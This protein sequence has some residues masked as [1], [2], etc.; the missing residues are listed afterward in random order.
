MLINVDDG[1]AK[2]RVAAVDPNCCKPR[3][4]LNRIRPAC[5]RIWPKCPDRS[6]SE[7]SLRLWPSFAADGST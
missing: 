2:Q 4:R 6:K 3:Q 7:P 1:L 5:D